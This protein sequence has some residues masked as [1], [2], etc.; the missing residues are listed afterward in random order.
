MRETR[1]RRKSK[2]KN[3]GR[4]QRQINRMRITTKKN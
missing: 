2:R 3:E 4:K 1:E